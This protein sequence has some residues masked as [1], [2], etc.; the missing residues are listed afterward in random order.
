MMTNIDKF[1]IYSGK[2]LALLLENFPIA[3]DINVFEDIIK[4]EN[5]TQ[6]EKNF[7]YHT[8]KALQEYGFIRY[9]SNDLSGELFINVTLSLKA[10]EVLKA[11]PKS[12]GGKSIGDRITDSVKL[13]KDEAIKSSVGLAFSQGYALISEA[14]KEVL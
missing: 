6:K 4:D 5:A 3:T 9:R 13:A 7:V 2:I 11:T 8:I 12:L 10:L 14:F 1:D